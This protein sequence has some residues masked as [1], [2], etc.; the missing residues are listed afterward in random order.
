M[1]AEL[2]KPSFEWLVGKGKGYRVKVKGWS[3]GVNWCW[4]VYLLITPEH[5]YFDKEEAFFFDLPFHGGVTYD[6]INT[7]DWPEYRYEHQRPCRYRE[8]GSDYAHLYD[9]FTE[10]SPYDGIPFKVLKD[11]K[12]L[13]SHL[14]AL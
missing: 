14:Q 9:A 12:D 4:N 2:A 13:L 1:N 3:N 11:A 6:R 8:I 10:E 7:V 5:Q